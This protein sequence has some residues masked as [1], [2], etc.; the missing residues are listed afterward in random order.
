MKE[1]PLSQGLATIVDDEDFEAVS[2]H[3]W[4][5]KR[6][7]DT[8]YAVR[9]VRGLVGSPTKE[10]VH[11]VVLSRMLGRPLAKDE[12][13]DHVNGDGL[14]NRRENLRPATAAQNGLN[15][16]RHSANPSSKYLGVHW[17]ERLQRWL[18]Q[19]R[20]AGKNTYLGIYRSETEAALAREFFITAH[21]ELQARSNFTG[22]ELTL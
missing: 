3:R 22:H 6:G 8:S 10:Y 18:T 19:I 14:D 5:A 17:D 15:C 2:A 13:T 7:R 11:Q 9:N 4:F 1:I 21:P 20:V 16:R 12:D